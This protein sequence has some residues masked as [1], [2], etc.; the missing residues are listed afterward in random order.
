[1]FDDYFISGADAVNSFL[2]D[3]TAFFEKLKQEALTQGTTLHLVDKWLELSANPTF[4]TC[5]SIAFDQFLASF[6]NSIR[7]L[8]HN[9][10]REARN[11]DRSTGA[12]LGPFWHGHKRFPQAAE[13]SVEDEL[14]LDYVFHCANILAYVFNLP[15]Q[16]RAQVASTVSKFTAKPWS[17]SGAKVNLDEGKGGEEKPEVKELGDDEA[18]QIASLKSK[19]SSLDLSKYRKLRP[20]DFEKDDDKNHHV[21]WITAATNLRSANY[22]IKP[23]TRAKCRLTAG[24]IIPA[25][26]TTT[27]CITGF[28][29]IELY[30]YVKNVVL[31]KYRAATINLA[32][33]IFC[34][35]NLPDPKLKKSGMDQALQ[36]PVVAI[37]EGFT[38]WDLVEI[39]KPNL[40]LQEFM[41]EFS[42]THHKA[43]IDMLSTASGKV[44]YNSVDLYQK[45]RKEISQARL[46]R[47]L[48]ELWLE[49]VGPIFPPSRNFLIFECSVESESGDLGIVPTIKYI[50][51]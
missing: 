26:A 4:E 47:N 17:F 41:D 48:V 28:I 30:K 18:N 2:E 22:F 29:G 12:D 34:S 39:N 15:E 13:F 51:K 45:G 24:K 14:H 25:I 36:L 42:A 8:T 35:E 6:R 46:K 27:A 5:V 32:T 20:A 50:F 10:P 9:F 31:D 16:S 44:F 1:M 43:V 7:D 40:T 38:C 21:D 23:S 19:L 49:I 3:R 37:P 33:N 11:V